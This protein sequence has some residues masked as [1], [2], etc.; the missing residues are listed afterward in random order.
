MTDIDPQAYLEV[1][2]A[3]EHVTVKVPLAGAGDQRV[4]SGL[5]EACASCGGAG[6]ILGLVIARAVNIFK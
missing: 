2:F 6:T 1:R 4:A 3:G 5:S